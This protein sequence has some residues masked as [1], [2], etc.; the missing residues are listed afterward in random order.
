MA[1]PVGGPRVRDRALN[2]VDEFVDVA[3]APAG[4]NAARVGADNR[5]HVDIVGR[6]RQLR[7]QQ[8]RARALWRERDTLTSGP[9]GAGCMRERTG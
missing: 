8:C 3:V 2:L 1:A 6:H 4:E 9:G 7:L 5:N